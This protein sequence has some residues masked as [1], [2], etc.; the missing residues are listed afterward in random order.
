MALASA[1][2]SLGKSALTSAPAIEGAVARGLSRSATQ[3][4]LRAA[5]LSIRRQTFLDI[6]R[7]FEGGEL[8]ARQWRSLRKDFLPNP[9]RMIESINPI[10]RNFSYKVKL[11]IIGA[12]PGE[13]QED[14][15][16]IATDSLLTPAEVEAEAE[17][18]IIEGDRYEHKN[19]DQPI[20]Y[21]VRKAGTKGV[22][23]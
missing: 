14:Y 4:L 10:R 9:L 12:A 21:D 18:Y 13:P 16:T 15:V 6:Y 3:S 19:Y 5:G 8:Q 23:S 7:Y 17:E 2:L 20:F 22:L 11:P 1:L